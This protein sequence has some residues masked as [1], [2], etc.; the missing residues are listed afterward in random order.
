MPAGAF[1][2]LPFAQWHWAYM[3]ETLRSIG[4]VMMNKGGLFVLLLIIAGAALAALVLPR[5]FSALQRFALIV[6]AIVAL[7][8]IGF[9][10][11]AYLAASFSG[12][13]VRAAISFWR[14]STH[15][16]LILAV[17]GVTLIPTRWFRNG[18]LNRPIALLVP[19]LALV[20]PI[21]TEKFLRFDLQAHTAYL[22]AAGHEIAELT[23]GAD[24]IVL[25]D[26][27]GDSSNLN[28]VQYQI[29]GCRADR[30]SEQSARA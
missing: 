5:R 6:G 27:E 13:E 16:G 28:Q 15:S 23:K 2:I 17:A 29:S 9:L 24:R 11:F 19:L 4:H 25:I 8:N 30:P 21:A 1:S 26:Q 14:Y 22:R 18:W 12:A 20:L 7:G 3:P 10:I